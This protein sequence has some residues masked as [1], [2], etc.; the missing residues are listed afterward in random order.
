MNP[1]SM[2]F[3]IWRVVINPLP[4]GNKIAMSRLAARVS[5]SRNS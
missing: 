5:A 1:A 3:E 4:H 2:L